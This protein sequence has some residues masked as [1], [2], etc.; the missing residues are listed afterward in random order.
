MARSINRLSP[1]KVATETKRGFHADG[2]GLYL[3]VSKFDT[4]S[5]VFRFTL[6]KKS[7]EMGLGSLHTVS[8]AEARQD[9]EKCR[10][11]LRESIDPINHRKSLKE[12]LRLEGVKFM[13]FR[14]CA[15]AYIHSHG[16]GWRN[17]KHAS[18]WRN[19]L[20][21]YAY[22]FFGDLSVQVVDTG[23][24][25]K[26]LEP[27]WTEKPETASR[28]RGRIEAV[29]NWATAR[30]YRQGENP[31]RWRGH[32]KE[33]LPAPAKVRKVKHHAAL[34]YSEIGA[35]MAELRQKEAVSAKGLE[36]L[37]LTAAR[38]GEVIDATWDEIDF[39]ERMWTV[40]GERMKSDEEHRVP[41]SAAALEVL[42]VMNKV[43]KS[44]FIF[45]GNRANRPLSNMAF[46]QLLK[47]MDRDDLTGHGFRSTFRDWAAEQTSFPNEVAEMALAHAV[48]DKVEAAYRRG[49][50]FEKR[51][52][53]M[54]AWATC[55][56][57]V[58]A[59]VV[60]FQKPKPRKEA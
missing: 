40:P 25:M 33:L 47:R 54:D 5:W 45:P 13:T 46:L 28:V 34:P 42:Q 48:G 11:M 39:A 6:N 55:M 15:E 43:R 26:A 49:D 10:K 57:A 35:F 37:I 53:I 16:A 23:L 56:E 27:I 52:K 12:A 31:A 41:L 36:F 8:L 32:L 4:K 58:E 44:D 20:K 17:V 30:E 1:R 19:T 38:T 29:L 22:P 60:P 21:T 7:R 50:L 59:E 24:V 18:Q 3:Q 9:A 51:R 2:G 14:E